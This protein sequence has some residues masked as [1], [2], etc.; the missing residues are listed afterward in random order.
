LAR[1]GDQLEAEVNLPPET[2]GTF[3]WRGEKTPL[4]PGVNRL[5]GE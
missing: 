3:N 1:K 5:L 2:E 4:K